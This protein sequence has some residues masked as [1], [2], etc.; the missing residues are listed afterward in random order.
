MRSM[1]AQNLNGGMTIAARADARK[2]PNRPS[3]APKE[4]S[5]HALR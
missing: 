1:N 5:S 2:A 3:E 4:R